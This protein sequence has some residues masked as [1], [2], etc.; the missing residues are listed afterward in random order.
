M[1]VAGIFCN[2]A[3]AFDCVNNEILL[4]KLIFNGTQGSAAN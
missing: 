4:T 2:L 1:H 3:E